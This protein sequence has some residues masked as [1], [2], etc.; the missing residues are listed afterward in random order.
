MARRR[1]RE[2]TSLRTKLLLMLGVVLL[3]VVIYALIGPSEGGVSAN[4]LPQPTSTIKAG[5]LVIEAIQRKAKLETISMEISNDITI[6]REHGF[7]GAC[8]ESITYLGY[9]SVSAGI[10]L[11]NISQEQVQVENDGYP[12]IAKVVITLP[13]AE[14]LHNELDTDNS[15]IVSQDTPR[16]VPG[17][18]HEIADMTLEAQSKLR[19]SAQA[20][21]LER[22]ILYDA[23]Q[24]AADELTQILH[25]AGYGNVIVQ[26]SSGRPGNPNSSA[27]TPVP[28]APTEN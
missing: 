18:S 21:A 14:I 28:T 6:T 2:G 12:S 7:L 11:R 22:G 8:T 26:T 16:W 27:I 1:D 20:A 3:G 23:E 15:R 9:Y 24:T 19:A 17:C 4:L 13:R 5:P 10:D 25:D